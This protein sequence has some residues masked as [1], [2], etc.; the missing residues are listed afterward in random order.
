MLWLSHKHLVLCIWK[1]KSITF[2][3]LLHPVSINGTKIDAVIQA[4]GLRNLL[5]PHVTSFLTLSIL[6]SYIPLLKYRQ[7]HQDLLILPAKLFYSPLPP[8]G[9]R[10]SIDAELFEKKF[11]ATVIKLLQRAIIT[12]FFCDLSISERYMSKSAMNGDLSTLDKCQ[13]KE[14]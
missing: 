6:A 7:N 8:T 11:K 2:C 5:R 14:L 10:Q 13:Y 3:P 12:N 1:N 4:R 9:K